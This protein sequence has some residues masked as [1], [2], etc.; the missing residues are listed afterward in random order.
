MGEEIMGERYL[1]VEPVE[2][3]PQQDDGGNCGIYMLKMAEFIM[4]EMDMDAIYP[5]A[6]PLFREKWQLSWF[7]TAREGRLRKNE[8]QLLICNSTFGTSSTFVLKQ[9]CLSFVIVLKQLCL[10]FVIVFEQHVV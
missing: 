4:V 1:E 8:V 7:Y 9:L 10:S 6:I 3:C 2:G 5:K